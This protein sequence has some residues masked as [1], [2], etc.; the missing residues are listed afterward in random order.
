MILWSMLWHIHGNPDRSAGW[1]TLPLGVTLIGMLSPSTIAWQEDLTRL[2]SWKMWAF[3][4]SVG[5]SCSVLRDT[6]ESYIPKF[7]WAVL[8]GAFQPTGRTE[9]PWVFEHCS[10]VFENRTEVIGNVYMPLSALLSR[11]IFR[12]SYSFLEWIALTV[13]RPNPASAYMNRLL[14]KKHHSKRAWTLHSC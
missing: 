9:L 14:S 4:T 2:E 11:W 12:R 3:K 8:I 1:R 13:P 7:S 5:C 6:T 10:W